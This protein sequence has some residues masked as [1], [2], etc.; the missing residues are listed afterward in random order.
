MAP[1]PSYSSTNLST[2]RRERKAQTL[3]S[4]ASSV[5]RRYW[6]VRA[7]CERSLSAEELGVVGGAGGYSY[8]PTPPAPS[9]ACSLEVP[10]ALP[11]LLSGLAGLG[12]ASRRRKQLA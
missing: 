4:T 10:A 6:S 7:C 12:L 1:V 2:S 9:S 5:A 11:L 3:N 8:C